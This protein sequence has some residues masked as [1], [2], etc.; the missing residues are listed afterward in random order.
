MLMC[1]KAWRIC[2]PVRVFCST[3][4]PS[5][6]AVLLKLRSRVWALRAIAVSSKMATDRER[7]QFFIWLVVLMIRPINIKKRVKIRTFFGI[8]NVFLAKSEFFSVETSLWG[9]RTG[10]PNT[11]H[12]NYP[13]APA[14]AVFLYDDVE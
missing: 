11:L 4:R 1:F 3:L 5:R 7:K 2:N 9:C 8:R 6:G 13:T 10:R 14:V 12:L